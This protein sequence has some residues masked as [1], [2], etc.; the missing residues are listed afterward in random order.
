M[1]C[2][3]WKLVSNRYFLF[4]TNCCCSRF[5]IWAVK[6]FLSNRSP[7]SRGYRLVPTDGR[8]KKQD[9]KALALNNLSWKRERKTCACA[10]RFLLMLSLLI[11]SLAFHRR[12]TIICSISLNLVA[13]VRLIKTQVA[14]NKW[15]QLS[16]AQIQI[17]IQLW[18]KSAA[19]SFPG[20][21][22]SASIVV[23]GRGERPWERGWKCGRMKLVRR[24]LFCFFR[25]STFA[26]L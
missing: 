20:S 9:R 21:L 15:L 1:M 10:W 26:A 23:G 4:I 12:I 11:L 17:Q 18:S 19:T 22:F 2:C 24:S 16:I 13:I 7:D 5:L 8:E 14:V 3:H 25:N 6:Y